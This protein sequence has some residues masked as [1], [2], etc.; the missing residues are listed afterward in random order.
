MRR[1]FRIYNLVYGN[2]EGRLTPLGDLEVND[3]DLISKV[4]LRKMMVTLGEPLNGEEIEIFMKRAEKFEEREGW[5]NYRRLCE[6]A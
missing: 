1:A 2:K 6:W 5:V 3:N 4:E